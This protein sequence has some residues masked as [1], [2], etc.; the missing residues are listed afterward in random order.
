M[1]GSRIPTLRNSRAAMSPR[2]Q[3]LRPPHSDWR[4]P[5][6]CNSMR[7]G[8]FQSFTAYGLRFGLRVNDPAALEAACA[9]APL[10]W[11][12]APIAEGDVLY[13]LRIAPPHT[14]NSH[15]LTCGSIVIASDPDLA[16]VLRLFTKHAELLTATLAHDCLFVH[17][18]VVGWRDRAI[19]VP[20][21]SFSGKTTLVKA[22]VEA[23]AIYYSDEFAILDRQG[24]VL[25][26]PLPLALRNGAGQ[27]IGQIPIAAI[28]GEVGTEPLPVGLVVVTQYQAGAKWR[29]RPLSAARALLALMDNTVA[30]QRE[31]EHSMPILR[32]AVVSATVIKSKRGEAAGVAQAILR[33][34]TAQAAA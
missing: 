15:L 18:G 6:M 30:A 9:A 1:V 27:S 33:Q 25:P 10:G 12:P 34:F 2:E 8:C 3:L 7:D 17:A 16:I 11:E 26:Y 24:L 22:L 31:P 14:S 23:G 5:V 13:T 32:A 20:G 21:R 28:G 19:L 4:S 29:P